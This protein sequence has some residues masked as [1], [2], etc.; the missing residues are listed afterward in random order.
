MKNI[1]AALLSHYAGEVTTLAILWQITRADGVIVRF[2]D[3]DQDITVSGAVYRA[4]AGFTPTA[5]QTTSD[6]S[7]D[8]LDVEGLI[9]EC[10]ISHADVLNGRLD[11]AEVRISRVNY[12]QPA[13]GIEKLRA[14]WV[15]EVTLT[16]DGYKA[17]LRGLLQLL[18]Q[19]IGLLLMPEC[20]ADLGDAR[21]RVALVGYTSPGA[22]EAADGD[23]GWVD[24]SLGAA[25]G[26]YVG[27]LVSWLSGANSGLKKEIKDHAAGGAIG[28]QEPMPNPISAGDTYTIHAGCDKTRATC[29]TKFSNVLNFRG[30][31]DIP[32]PDF[33]ASNKK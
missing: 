17:E 10:L 14:G 21:C 1:P 26:F 2:T 4:A 7:V 16:R 11:R 12:A 25:A 3:H 15:G 27:G 13:D 24:A 23:R 9:S 29:K 22:V 18:Q 30:F 20:N 5:I 8:N 33:L 6:L 19:P 28:L 31:P 32:G